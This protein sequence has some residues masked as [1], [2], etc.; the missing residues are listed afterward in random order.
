MKAPVAGEARLRSLQRL[1]FPEC[2]ALQRLLSTQILNAA[3][4]S[5][6]VYV[7][8][9]HAQPYQGRRSRRAVVSVLARRVLTV[10]VIV[11]EQLRVQ[12]RVCADR[13][14]LDPPPAQSV[15]RL[16][17]NQHNTPKASLKLF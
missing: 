3:C 11:G 16:V 4:S 5:L 6:G 10:S 7:D 1:L 17:C 8:E 12:P 9:L 2:R 15:Y 13:F 14:C